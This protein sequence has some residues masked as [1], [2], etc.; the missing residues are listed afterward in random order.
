MQTRCRIDSTRYFLTPNIPTE[1]CR[2]C[3]LQTTHACDASDQNPSLDTKCTNGNFFLTNYL[4]LTCLIVDIEKTHICK[5]ATKQ[6]S[7][8]FTCF[9]YFSILLHFCDKRLANKQ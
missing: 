9:A 7:I 3:Q 2:Y 6:Y 1:N 5:Y 8:Y 4:N